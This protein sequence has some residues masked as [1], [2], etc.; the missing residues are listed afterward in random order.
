MAARYDQAQLAIA[1]GALYMH[2]LSE[3]RSA[4]RI[5]GSSNHAWPC[6]AGILQDATDLVSQL[7]D[8]VEPAA[9]SGWVCK[10]LCC[11]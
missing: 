3:M 10:L 6:C 11:R 5:A 9:C 2:Q 1:D 7:L 8:E 4:G